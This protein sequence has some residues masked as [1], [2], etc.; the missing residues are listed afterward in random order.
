MKSR[1]SFLLL[2][3]LFAVPAHAQ[4]S[5]NLAWNDCGSFGQSV[6]SFACDT[7]LGGHTL[8]ASFVS[9]VPMTQLVG[10]DL[11]IDVTYRDGSV[12]SWWNIPYWGNG[13][14]PPIGV[15]TSL[16]AGPFTC[17]DP[18]TT[19][20]VGGANVQLDKPSA[21]RLRIQAVVAVPS[22]HPQTVDASTEYY[23]IQVFIPNAQTT[24]TGAC[25][26]CDV[27]A[28]LELTRFGLYQPA[29][30][31]DYQITTAKDNVVVGWQN[32]GKTGFPGAPTPAKVTTW[33]A[34][35]GLYR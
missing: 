24:G 32:D 23:G 16:A 2:A 15:Q 3:L 22:D 21:G 33:G 11:W 14:R 35:K 12:P 20:S 7:N 5:M 19:Q 8:Y 30:V 25:A 28:R 9:P 26:G 31:G 13:C 27:P 4:G 6:E 1:S 18:W 34:V 17:A 29:G 10:A